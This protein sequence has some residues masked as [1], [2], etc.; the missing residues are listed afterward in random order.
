MGVFLYY[1]PG[2]TA[3]EFSG[4]TIR[5][6]GLEDV[7]RDTLRNKATFSRM[8]IANNVLSGGPD[9][10]SGV[11]VL[12]APVDGTLPERINFKPAFQEWKKAGR[13]WLGVD[14]EEPPTPGGLRR[15]ILIRG[16]EYELGDGQVWECPIVREEGLVN[17]LPQSMGVDANGQFEMHTLPAWQWAWELAGRAFEFIFTPA[18]ERPFAEA[19]TEAVRLLGINYRI[20]PHEATRIGLIDTT[21][22]GRVYSAAVDMEKVVE[23]HGGDGKKK[24]KESAPG[25]VNTSPGPP[26]DS[27]ATP[28]A[29]AISSC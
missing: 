28:P 3:G 18:A 17:C 19:H 26:G 5:D 14:K 8:V 15:E 29:A 20:G 2:V 23:L 25:P 10:M 27:P 6:F 12:Q 21:N 16:I 11:I 7:F 24:V 1:L 9:G 13:H 22:F 4:D